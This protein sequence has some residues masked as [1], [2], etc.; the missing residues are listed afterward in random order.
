MLDFLLKIIWMAWN[1]GVRYAFVGKYRIKLRQSGVGLIGQ[2]PF[3]RG[4]GP[5]FIVRTDLNFFCYGCEVSG[6]VDALGDCSA[7]PR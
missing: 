1:D 7:W 5:T 2:C 3:C 4:R 6:T